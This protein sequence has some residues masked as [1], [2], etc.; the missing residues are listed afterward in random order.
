MCCVFFAR[1]LIYPQWTR[2]RLTRVL[3]GVF[4]F[5]C[6]FFPPSFGRP[7]TSRI[8]AGRFLRTMS[9]AAHYF[10]PTFFFF[11][12]G[13]APANHKTSVSARGV[14]FQPFPLF[15]EVVCPPTFFPV[16]VFVNVSRPTFCASAQ[17]GMGARSGFLNFGGL[18]PI[19]PTFGPFL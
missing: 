2:A 9:S 13:P 18:R 5:F 6:T 14:F 8:C 10:S 16:R 7:V 1:S 19:C 3:A 15:C 12:K 11:F 17:V 4:R